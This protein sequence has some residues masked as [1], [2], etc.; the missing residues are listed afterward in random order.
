MLEDSELVY[1]TVEIISAEIHLTADLAEFGGSER[2]FLFVIDIDRYIIECSVDSHGE[3]VPLVIRIIA[4]NLPLVRIVS[5]DKCAVAKCYFG[6]FSIRHSAGG[7][8]SAAF[9]WAL[10]PE[11]ERLILFVRA[12]E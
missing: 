12:R 4:V 7:E 10:K 1:I 2:E 11:H 3:M 8:D 6:T 5:E 9:A